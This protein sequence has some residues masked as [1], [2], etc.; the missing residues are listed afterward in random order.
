MAKPY[1]VVIA[2]KRYP[3]RYE[4][5]DADEIEKHASSDGRTLQQMIT[6]RAMEKAAVVWG[7]LKHADR[8]LT[9]AQV[10]AML[11]AHVDVGGEWDRD[12]YL[13]CIRALVES[14]LLG[15]YNEREIDRLMRSLGEGEDE[16]S[17][18]AKP[19]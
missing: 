13:P 11:Q 15:A 7:G 4:L 1:S 19:A 6:G 2:G 5:P 9:P 16:A 8:K 10:L 12:V 18:E 3:V 14:R 17:G